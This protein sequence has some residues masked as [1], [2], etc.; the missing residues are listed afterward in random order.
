[1]KTLL[2]RDRFYHGL[3]TLSPDN[4]LYCY[5]FIM[6]YVFDDYALRDISEYD[7]PEGVEA[8]LRTIVANIDQDLQRYRE[9][10]AERRGVSGW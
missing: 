4:R 2:F 8:V 3:A 5:D 1:M 7:L 6:S 9:R 10:V